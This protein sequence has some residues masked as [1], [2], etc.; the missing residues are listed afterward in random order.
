MGEQT[1]D[2]LQDSAVTQ[3]GCKASGLWVPPLAETTSLLLWGSETADKIFHP[4]V[5]ASR[6][7]AESYHPPYGPQLIRLWL[8]FA[9]T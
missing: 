3:S 7:F 4:H 9:V 2:V 5:P 6:P 1:W 8:A